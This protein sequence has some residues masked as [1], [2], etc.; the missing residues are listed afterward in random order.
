MLWLTFFSP[1]WVAAVSVAVILHE[2]AHLAACRALGIE[3]LDIRALPWGLT[4]S[5]PV[6]HEPFA[7]IA[8]S[9]AGPMAN[10][11]LLFFCPAISKYISKDASE[12][13][14]LANISDGVLNLIPALPLD[15]G[16]MLKALLCSRFGIVRG[17]GYMMR[18]TLIVSCIIVAL[19]VCIFIVSGDNFSFVMAGV[20]M[21]INTRHEKEI[22]MHLKKKILTGEIK[23]IKRP[24]R[25]Y[26]DFSSHALCLINHISPSYTVDICVM[27]SGKICGYIS[28]RRLIECVLKNSTITVGECIE[29]N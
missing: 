10:F 22:V 18:L 27:Q 29:K 26:A 4:A 1:K 13:F 23:S 9:V 28:Q 24:R 17:F 12:L 25:V 19:G 2:A 7:Q 6:I 5:A 21:L 11:F 15:G 8:V 20:F 16:I 14:A 3:V